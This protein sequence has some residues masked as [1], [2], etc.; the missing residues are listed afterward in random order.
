MPEILGGS[1][2]GRPSSALPPVR[3]T[4]GDVSIDLSARYGTAPAW[5]RPVTLAAVAVV[6]A[7]FLAWLAWVV[8]HESTPEVQSGDA[9]Y[10]V[11]SDKQVEA[12]VT[13]RIADGA[14]D[15]TCRLQAQGSGHEVVGEHTFTPV[16]GRNTVVFRTMRRANAVESL[17]CTA[18]GQ[19]RPK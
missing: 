18:E 2:S 19:D 9:Q 16:E 4:I 7:A 8:V 13:V 1:L 3:G 5:R 11:V 14:R 17:G 15:V 10:R 6:A 12:W